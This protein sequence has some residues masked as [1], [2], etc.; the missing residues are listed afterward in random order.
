MR[1]A[2]RMVVL[3]RKLWTPAALCTPVALGSSLSLWLD[4]DDSSTITLNGSTVSQWDDKSGN[5]RHVSQATAVNQPT[6]QSTGLNGKGTLN[7][8]GKFIQAQ[9]AWVNYT[10]GLQVISVFRNRNTATSVS[11]ANRI[12]GGSPQ[13]RLQNIVIPSGNEFQSRIFGHADATEAWIGRASPMPTLNQWTILGTLYN[14][15]N[16]NSAVEIYLNAQKSDTTNN[17]NGVFS[18]QTTTS[19]IPLAIGAQA[20]GG[21]LTTGDYAEFIVIQ[22]ALST[23]DRQR[24]EGYLAHKWGLI[25]NLPSDHP[26]KS[27]PP[28]A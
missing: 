25:A 13:T 20:N 26:F 19:S 14:G 22:D 8:N 15:G 2:T 18:K 9:T 21:T 4:A 27:T 17:S 3:G 16:N 5:G 23:T 24:L 7:F 6:Y 11:Y 1:T 28:I 12:A 10:N